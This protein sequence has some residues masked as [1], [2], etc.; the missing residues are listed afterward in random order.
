[1]T[2]ERKDL[3]DVLIARGVAFEDI[4]IFNLQTEDIYYLMS[5]DR[6][7][8]AQAAKFL[9]I[10]RTTIY[11]RLQREYPYLAAMRNHAKIPV[12]PTMVFHQGESQYLAFLFRFRPQKKTSGLKP[13]QPTDLAASAITTS[14]H[15]NK[16]EECYA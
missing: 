8:I 9:G 5:Y 15:T 3:L 13:H 4:K 2:P 10:G 12:T 1:M 14:T 7:A 16:K 6:V 11:R